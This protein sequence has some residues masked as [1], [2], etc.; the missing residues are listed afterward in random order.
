M[1]N[2]LRYFSYPTANPLPAFATILVLGAMVRIF[3]LAGD[4]FDATLKSKTLG[5]IFIIFGLA[6]ISRAFAYSPLWTS[7][8]STW[9]K[10]VPWNGLGPQPLSPRHLSWQDALFVLLSIPAAWLMKVKPL[11]TLN[12]C[13]LSFL[14][15]YLIC[16]AGILRAWRQLAIPYT[17]AF[18]LGAIAL[19][20]TG[21]ALGLIILLY[22]LTVAGRNRAFRTFVA[23]SIKPPAP[24]HDFTA[25]FPTSFPTTKVKNPE[26]IVFSVLLGWLAFCILTAI[27]AFDPG[28]A[29]GLSEQYAKLQLTVVWAE[30]QHI[31]WIIAIGCALVRAA[32][33]CATYWPPI[34]LLGRLATGRL[35]IPGYD[36]VFIAPIC[37][38]LALVLQQS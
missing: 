13:A 15:P 29:S 8:Y 1:K 31:F 26:P 34:S 19:L 20:P 4:P 37:T 36:K 27:M 28:V 18:G 21:W 14:I 12:A 16:N 7:S 24:A 25:W 5:W 9:L 32:T 3:D 30:V 38:I 10:T 22:I 6:G 11:F 35:I 17:L 23:D 33:Y 2:L